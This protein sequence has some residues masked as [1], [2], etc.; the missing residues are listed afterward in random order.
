M[1]TKDSGNTF[2]YFN[3]DARTQ[4]VLS[5]IKDRTTP[6]IINC[7]QME[8]F[9]ANGQRAKLETFSNKGNQEEL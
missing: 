4:L 6:P 1:L 8:D 3:L 2:S 5:A 9:D 7:F